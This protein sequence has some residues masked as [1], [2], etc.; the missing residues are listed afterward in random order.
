MIEILGIKF[1]YETIAFF[2]AFL[3]SEAIG[4]SKY[5]DNS[6]AQLFITL[7]NML[8]PSRSEDDKLNEIRKTL[9]Q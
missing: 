7:V 6:L 4:I 1:T 9:G 2:V 8:R 3:A 5:K